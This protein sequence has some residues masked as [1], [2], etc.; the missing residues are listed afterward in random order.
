MT[1]ESYAEI[2]ALIERL[3]RA[4]DAREITPEHA[5]DQLL[6]ATPPGHLHRMGAAAQLDAWRTARTRYAA[7]ADDRRRGAAGITQPVDVRALTR[8]DPIVFRFPARAQGE[9]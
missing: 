7:A 6:A 9:S 4:V 3:G 5:V 1:P 2:G 8:R